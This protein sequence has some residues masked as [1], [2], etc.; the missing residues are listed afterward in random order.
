VTVM[1]NNRAFT[2]ALKNS[3]PRPKTKTFEV[4]L[5]IVGEPDMAEVIWIYMGEDSLKYLDY[6]APALNSQ[7]KWWR[8]LEPKNTIRSLLRTEQGRVQIWKMLNDASAWL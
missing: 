3:R 8:F 5:D 6:P 1:M 2:S 7:K 4:L